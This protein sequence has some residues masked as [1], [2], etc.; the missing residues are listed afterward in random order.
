V[1]ERR[2]P[3][4]PRRPPA[5]AAP[6]AIRALRVAGVV[7]ATLL[8]PPA[9]HAEEPAAAP[10]PFVMSADRSNR[11]VARV[12]ERLYAEAFRRLG[13]P[14]Q[15]VE[16]SLTRRAALSDAGAIDGEMARVRA[17]GDAHPNLVRV[18]EPIFDFSFALY[19][20]NPE[21]RL[22]RLGDLAGTSY[23]VEYR[24]GILV[25]EEALGKLVPPERLSDVPTTEQGVKKLL[26]GRTDL[27]CELGD[28][29][30]EDVLRAPEYR[31]NVLHLV[32]RFATLPTYP[33]L[34]QKHAA[35]AP[36]LA[37]VLRQMKA[38]GLFEAWLREA[39]PEREAR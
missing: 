15:V 22:A 30:V 11:L 6:L 24:R 31:G 2:A 1:I 7:A 8:F 13:V 10:R 20:A 17:Y 39:Q 26:A 9:A 19:S 37:A 4:A 5:A 35:L 23:L 34:H 29:Y 14:L 18:E 32:L 33:Y 38:E 16:D 36:R 12:F 3:A 25:C 21:I 28:Y 27:F